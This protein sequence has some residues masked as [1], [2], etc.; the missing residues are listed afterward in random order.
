MADHVTDRKRNQAPRLDE[1][2]S[3]QAKR[4]VS[5][6]FDDLMPLV[7]EHRSN[8][9]SFAEE[10]TKA[11]VDPEAIERLRRNQVELFDRASREV[12]SSLT[13]LASLLTPEQRAE[14]VSMAKTFRH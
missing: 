4:I 1:I 9:E 8:H 5:D 2:A 6:T 7:Q 13:E 3:E 11:S 12:S 14:L 10:M